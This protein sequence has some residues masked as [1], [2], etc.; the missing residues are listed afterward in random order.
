VEVPHPVAMASQSDSTVYYR[1]NWTAYGAYGQQTQVMTTYHNYYGGWYLTLPGY[2]H[3]NLTI[4]RSSEETSGMRGL[5]FAKWNGRDVPPE[6]I[7]TVYALTGDDRQQRSESDGKFILA[8]KGETVYCASMGS[9]DWAKRLSEDDVRAM[10]HF[11]RV[12]WNTGEIGS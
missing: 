10:F 2:W 6:D 4:F 3:G 5:T 1:L 9:C 11:I 8:E 12:N 7:L